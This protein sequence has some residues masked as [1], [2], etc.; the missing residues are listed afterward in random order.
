MNQLVSSSYQAKGGFRQRSNMASY[1]INHYT[2]FWCDNVITHQLL[3]LFVIY[4]LSPRLRP[5]Q[6][7]NAA[8]YETCPPVGLKTTCF[9]IQIA[10]LENLALPT[11]WTQGGFVSF[12]GGIPG[13]LE[14]ANLLAKILVKPSILRVPSVKTTWDKP[15]YIIL[16]YS[17]L[18]SPSLLVSAAKYK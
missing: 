8:G 2:R 4:Q 16:P 9:T 11:P 10:K 15:M 13:Y 6:H 14:S 17:L 7:E 3:I 18:T 12:L 1:P 5:Q